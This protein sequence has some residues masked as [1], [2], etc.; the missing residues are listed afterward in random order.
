MDKRHSTPDEPSALTLEQRA[1][2]ARIAKV[3][4]DSLY[5]MRLP[6]LDPADWW[7]VYAVLATWEENN[8]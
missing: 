1:H 4:H 2:Y 3:I 8:A 6:E 5:K 7:R